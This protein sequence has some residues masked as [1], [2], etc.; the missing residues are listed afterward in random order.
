MIGTSDLYS[1]I[2]SNFEFLMAVDHAE[3]V[4]HSSRLLLRACGPGELSHTGR[5]LEDILTPA[6]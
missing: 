5:R 6:S 4:L 3:T 1:F 2:E